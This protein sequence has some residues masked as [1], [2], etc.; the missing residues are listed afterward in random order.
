MTDGKPY[1][2]MEEAELDAET[3]EQY[4][5]LKSTLKEYMDAN[6]D[7]IKKPLVGHIYRFAVASSQK[8]QFRKALGYLTYAPGGTSIVAESSDDNLL[9]CVRQE[10]GGRYVFKFTESGKYLAWR[11][12]SGGEN[13][14]KG[15]VDAYDEEESYA[16]FAID[17][18]KKT[19]YAIYDNVTMAGLVSVTS[20]RRSTTA[21]A[22]GCFVVN[23][24][25]GMGWNAGTAPFFNGSYTSAFLITDYDIE[26]GVTAPGSSAANAAIYNLSGQQVNTPA[27]G[28]YITNGKK[29]VVK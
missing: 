12:G 1:Y 5:L 9:E 18:I 20:A 15:Y 22:A 27:R 21:A 23:D 7:N 8:T 10:A 25:A 11:G 29:V 13:D 16:S 14:N 26:T 28:I 4:N 2:D 24:N 19:A 6:V 3:L 17:N